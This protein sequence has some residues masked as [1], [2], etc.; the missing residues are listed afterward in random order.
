MASSKT[1]SVVVSYIKHWDSN[2][3]GTITVAT[4]D[5][6]EGVE[7]AKQDLLA[8]AYASEGVDPRQELITITKAVLEDQPLFPYVGHR[9]SF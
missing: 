1:H 8:E 7:T 5:L 6:V 2:T 9:A 3:K 4:D